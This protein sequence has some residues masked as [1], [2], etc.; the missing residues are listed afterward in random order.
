MSE[1]A[2]AEHLETPAPGPGSFGRVEPDGTVYVRTADGERRVGQVPDVGPDE[3]LSFFVRRFEALELE[4]SLLETRIKSGALSPDDAGSAIKTV[5]TAVTDAHAVGDLDRLLARLE[6]L[7]P[8]IA[9]QRAA[10]RA[11][12]AKQNEEARAAKE[13]FV[14]EAEKLAA[15]NDWRG[16]VNRFR[17]L[18]EE[19][20]ALPRLDR[21]TDD[22]LWHRFSSARTTYTRRRKAQFAQQAEQ[23]EGA[24]ATK[25]KLVAEAEA[26]ATSTDWGPTTGAYRDLMTRWKAAG[27]APR[28]LDD[29]LWKRFRAA[30][31]TFFAAKQA[32]FEEQDAEFKVN[33]DAKEALLVEGEALLPITDLDAA[34]AGYRDLL[35]RWTAIGKVPRDAIKPLDSRLRAI[36]SAIKQAEDEQWRRTNP[37]ARARAEDTAAKLEAQI[38]AL[39]SKATRAEARGDQ[40]AAREATE[41]ANTYREWLTQAQKAVSDFSG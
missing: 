18:L 23:R 5:R 32:T 37:E 9:E 7:S 31:D 20:K 33:Q 28:G 39:E 11:E 30:Q 34:K 12:R 3:A 17:A 6:A 8:M 35:E 40:K 19:W 2:K 21:A 4:V 36:E 15:G 1:D 27:P 26:L 38:E 14:E 29:A 41:S 25:E 10:R 13:K 24:R 16:G 22:R